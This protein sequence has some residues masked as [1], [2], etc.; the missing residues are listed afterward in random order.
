MNLM[1]GERLWDTSP[2]DELMT[3]IPIFKSGQVVVVSRRPQKKIMAAEAAA[4][5]ASQ[6]PFL[7]VS[8][9]ITSVSLPI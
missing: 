2:V 9:A 4:S 7:F 8:G 5:V 3:A 1:T 6:V